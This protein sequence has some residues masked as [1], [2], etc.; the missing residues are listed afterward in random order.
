[1]N[2]FKES[3]TNADFIY[4]SYKNKGLNNQKAVLKK[5]NH[6]ENSASYLSLFTIKPLTRKFS[7][8]VIKITNKHNKSN[9]I[10]ISNIENASDNLNTIMNKTNSIN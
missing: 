5:L 8:R 1:M 10:N 9:V 7:N 4:D 3:F 2:R 6:R